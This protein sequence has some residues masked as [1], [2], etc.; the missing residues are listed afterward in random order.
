MCDDLLFYILVD[1]RRF[2]GGLFF[3]RLETS[4]V[5]QVVELHMSDY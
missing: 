5:G 3:F 2:W 1:I 4:K